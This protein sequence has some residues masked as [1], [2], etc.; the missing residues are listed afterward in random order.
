M[1]RQTGNRSLQAIAVQYEVH[2]AESRSGF[3]C[4]FRYPD[5]CIGVLLAASPDREGVGIPI[6]S[7]NP[8][9]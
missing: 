3:S 8:K 7:C 1:F 9:K 2:S 5:R 6:P 4:S